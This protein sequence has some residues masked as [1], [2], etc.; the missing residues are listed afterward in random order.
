MFS[1]CLSGNIFI[2][3][4]E[5]AIGEFARATHCSKVDYKNYQHK[6]LDWTVS[7]ED[8]FFLIRACSL[9]CKDA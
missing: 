6:Y 4:P 7:S 2:S 1:K 5:F 3:A 8:Q 9:Q